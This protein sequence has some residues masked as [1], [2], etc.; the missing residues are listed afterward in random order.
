MAAKQKKMPRKPFSM[1]IYDENKQRIVEIMKMNLGNIGKSCRE[2]GICRKTFDLWKEKCPEF[3]E[4]LREGR[5]ELKDM[6]EQCVINM[7][8]A[9]HLDAAKYYL[10]N[11]AKDREYGDDKSITHSTGNLDSLKEVLEHA[12][13]KH[14]S[15]Y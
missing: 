14:E 8:A 13:S 5:E 6:A 11:K 10:N 9:N 7:I 3:A 1:H 2:G 12:I 4:G 15:D